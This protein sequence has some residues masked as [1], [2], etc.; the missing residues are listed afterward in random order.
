MKFYSNN[1]PF[2]TANYPCIIYGE[3]GFGMVFFI[4]KYNVNIVIFL[5]TSS[6]LIKANDYNLNKITSH[7]INFIGIRF[8]DCKENKKS[9]GLRAPI[10]C[11]WIQKLL[12][13]FFEFF[14]I[15]KI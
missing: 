7:L 9:L 10:R 2:L 4:T 14:L 11:V 15:L 5:L 1:D 13:V 6:P 3:L 8:R 12:P